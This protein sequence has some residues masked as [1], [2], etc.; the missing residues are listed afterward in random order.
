MDP[1]RRAID[2]VMRGRGLYDKARL[3]LGQYAQQVRVAV[4]SGWWF[5]GN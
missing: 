1:A 4:R 5:T 3:A 2:A